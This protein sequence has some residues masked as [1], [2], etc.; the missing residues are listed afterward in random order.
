MA[1]IRALYKTDEAREVYSHVTSHRPEVEVVRAVGE[2]KVLALIMRI[3]LCRV[4]EDAVAA[5][6]RWPV[7]DARI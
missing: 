2:D 7:N 6:F 1:S 3:R 5:G 4:D